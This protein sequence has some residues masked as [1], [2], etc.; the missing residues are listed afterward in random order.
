VKHKQANVPYVVMAIISLKIHA[1]V[2]RQ[3]ASPANFRAT[4][5]IASLAT[6]FIKKIITKFLAIAYLAPPTA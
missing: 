4:A 6:I 3:V 1:R 2:A 5:L